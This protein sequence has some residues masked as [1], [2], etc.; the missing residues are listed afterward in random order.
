[1][2]ETW[3]QPLSCLPILPH[4]DQTDFE[5]TVNLS[6]STRSL[7]LSA[8]IADIATAE[9]SRSHPASLELALHVKRFIQ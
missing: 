9:D 5:R 8:R 3:R 2:A 4:E 7:N 1:V 6:L